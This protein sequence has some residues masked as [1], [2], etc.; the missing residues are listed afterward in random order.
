MPPIKNWGKNLGIRSLQEA[1]KNFFRGRN[2]QGDFGPGLVPF[3]LPQV[4]GNCKGLIRLSAKLT[5]ID[6]ID[7]IL[8]RKRES[9]D[10]FILNIVEG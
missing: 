10:P 1:P 7:R 2:R 4:L 3:I 5:W 6:R 9:I 8:P